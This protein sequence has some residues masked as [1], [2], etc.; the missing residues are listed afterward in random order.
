MVGIARPVLQE[1][2]H[3]GEDAA[4]KWLEHYIETIKRMM[5]L[6]GVSDIKTLRFEK[7]RL[8]P[9]GRAREWLLRRKM[10]KQ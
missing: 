2:I 1:L 6:I 10:L 8:I 7:E 5:F 4:K 3:N 9:R